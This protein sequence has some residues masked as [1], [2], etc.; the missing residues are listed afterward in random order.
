MRSRR[1]VIVVRDGRPHTKPARSTFSKAM[2]KLRADGRRPLS[3]RVSDV[4]SSGAPEAENASA[5][6]PTQSAWAMNGEISAAL[7]APLASRRL[8]Q[9]N[10][11]LYSSV[12]VVPTVPMT[13]ASGNRAAICWQA[14]QP[15][16]CAG[17]SSD[18]ESP[19]SASTVGPMIGSNIGPLR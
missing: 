6:N 5:I 8:T 3:R 7:T 13:N 1:H 2:E 19:A 15:V 4:L 18:G 14:F 10:G 12:I 11:V 16:Q 17:T 9:I